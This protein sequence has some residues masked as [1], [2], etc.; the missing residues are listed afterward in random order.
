VS[1][2][3]TNPDAEPPPWG[4][5]FWDGSQWVLVDEDAMTDE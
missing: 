5:W 3:L 2:W 1:D 4:E